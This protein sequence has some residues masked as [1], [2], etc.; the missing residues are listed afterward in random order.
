MEQH[1]EFLEHKSFEKFLAEEDLS[2]LTIS[3]GSGLFR[4][5]NSM[6]HSCCPNVV[7]A[8]CFKDHRI[9][10]IALRTIS[11]GEQLCFSYIDE[12]QPFCA[13]QKELKEKYLFDCT[14]NK[15]QLHRNQ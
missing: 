10:V 12:T 11:K 14:C 13:R 6:N 15:C 9:K 1:P 3:G 5:G 7:V 2:S 4:L 8:T